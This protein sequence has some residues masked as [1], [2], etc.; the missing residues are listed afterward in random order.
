MLHVMEVLELHSCQV[1]N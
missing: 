1:F